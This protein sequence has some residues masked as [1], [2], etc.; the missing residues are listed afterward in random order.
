M[1]IGEAAEKGGT[2]RGRDDKNNKLVKA[3]GNKNIDTAESNK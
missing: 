2:I 3:M 1:E